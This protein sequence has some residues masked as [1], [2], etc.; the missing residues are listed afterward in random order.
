MADEHAKSEAH[1]K[2]SHSGGG[3]GHGGSHGGG[4]H[5]EHEGAPEWLI[6]FA[7]NVTLMMGFFVILLAVNMGPKGGGGEDNPK[8]G[9]SKQ[10][11][12]TLLD[13]QI[14]IREAF[15]NPVNLNS[16]DPNDRVL[17]QRLLE[18]RGKSVAKQDGPRGDEHAVQSLRKSN[19]F[20]LCG[21]VPFDD[22]ATTL[23][24]AARTTALD[25][26]NHLRGLRMIVDVRGHVSAAEAFHLPDQGMRL[27]FDR[28]LAVA[29][30][31]A[32]VGIDWRQIRLIACADNDRVKAITYDKA[33][34]QP[35]ER[36]EVVLT[37]E[38]MPDYVPTKTPAASQ[39]TE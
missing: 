13:T 7:D 30:V 31:L 9:D 11:P 3:G 15:N 34:H 38:V 4:V 28:V 24:A 14:A 6:S 8:S 39:P 37:D 2:A 22:N 1:G 16:M 17:I 35:N 19:Y 26:A 33:G 36:V 29:K 23:T 25:I 18:R 20:K 12:P 32:E 27:S 5:E 10:P 21:A